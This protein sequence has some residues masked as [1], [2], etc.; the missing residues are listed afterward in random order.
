[1][2][3]PSLTGTIERVAPAVV[4]IV[5]KKALDDVKRELGAMRRGKK[6]LDVLEIPPEKIDAKGMV[7]VDGGS[8]FFVDPSGIILTNKHVIAEPD[9]TYTVITN[10]PYQCPL[11][12]QYRLCLQA[13]TK[14]PC[15]RH[16]VLLFARGQLHRLRLFRQAPTKSCATPL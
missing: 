5:I 14:A 8:G 13:Y 7:E 6:K 16:Q 1:M 11:P 2:F 9:S 10:A 15:H 4:S 12:E 3:T